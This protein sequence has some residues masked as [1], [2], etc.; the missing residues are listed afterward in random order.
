MAVEV[1]R[2]T[3]NRELV[4]Y[5]QFPERVELTQGPVQ[6]QHTALLTR[7]QALEATQNVTMPAGVSLTGNME[8]VKKV[9]KSSDQQLNDTDSN[10]E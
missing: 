6:D 1:S 9:A 3:S 10:D 7:E 2:S 4:V 8:P 5:H